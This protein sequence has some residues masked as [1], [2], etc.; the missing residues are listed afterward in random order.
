MKDLTATIPDVAPP[1][2]ED[3]RNCSPKAGRRLLNPASVA[4]L[5]S[6]EMLG[7]VQ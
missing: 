3:D 1:I 2:S 7:G 6:R 4:W 5:V